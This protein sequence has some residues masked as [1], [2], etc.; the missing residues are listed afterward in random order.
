MTAQE[1]L[2]EDTI[3]ELTHATGG[4][5]GGNQIN[6]QFEALIQQCFG[7]AVIDEYK[8]EHEESWFN[9]EMEFEQKKRAVRPDGMSDISFNITR[10]FE[11]F[12]K[13]KLNKSIEEVLEHSQTGV[14]MRRNNMVITEMATLHLIVSN[15]QPIISHLEM[16]LRKKELRRVK[17]IF[18]VGGYAE[19]EFLFRTISSEFERQGYHVLSPHQPSTA[20]LKGAVLFGIDPNKVISRIARKTYGWCI[21]TK[22]KEGEHD[23]ARRMQ[24]EYGQYYCKNVFRTIVSKGDVMKLGDKGKWYTSPFQSDARY[25]TKRLYCSD[26]TDVQYVDE[27][28]VDLLAEVRLDLPDPAQGKDREIVTTTL[29]T[30]TEIN[31]KAIDKSTGKTVTAHIAFD[32]L[33]KLA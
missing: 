26:R 33:P 4:S 25:V 28:G 30:G 10:E 18:L 31:I 8:Q 1:I 32:T 2:P 29:F 14:I 11:V 16:L 13:Q 7:K 24:D 6:M 19:S 5:W 21:R 12:I 27:E 3:K 17:Y 15:N 23:P 9:W 22:F 20:V